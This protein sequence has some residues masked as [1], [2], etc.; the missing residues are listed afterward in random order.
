MDE[1]RPSLV[2]K[3]TELESG[4][5]GGR[6][7]RSLEQLADPDALWE[8]VQ[9]E[10]P[11][12]AA[13]VSGHTGR[14]DFLKL[15]GAVLAMAGLSGCV[16]RPPR[17]T[18]VPYVEAP[19]TVVP[20]KPL[21]FATAMPLNG[22]LTGIL[23]ESHLGRPTKLEG[24]PQHPASL[25]GTNALMHGSLLDLYDPARAQVVTQ[26]GQIN[27]W[28]TF[29]EALH[30]RLEP[31]QGEG[32]AG[33]RILTGTVTSPTLGAQLAR[34]LERFPQARWH[35]Y[36]PVGQDSLRAGAQLAF[37]EP[38][39]TVYHFERAR[40]IV[41]LDAD[42]LFA[43][44]GSVRYALDFIDM[45]RLWNQPEPNRLYVVESTPTMTGAK[46]DNRLALRAGQIEHAARMLA[47]AVGLDVE[48][49]PA[50]TFSQE[51]TAWIEAAARD[52][53]Q[54]RGAGIVIAGPSQPP[55]VHTLAHAIN[56][57]LENTGAAVIHIAPVEAQ[58]VDQLQSLRTLV[59][60]MAA[61]QVNTL[62]IID[63][64]PVLNAP[65]DFDFA[66]Q[67]AQVDFSVQLSLYTDETSELCRWH[68]PMAH[69]LESW[70]DGRAY[71]GTAS[72][73]QPLIAPLFDGKSA[74]ELLAALLGE[75][76]Q[77]SAYEIVRGFWDGYYAELAQPLQ[78][79]AELF[80]R[81]ALYDGVVAGTAFAPVEAQATLDNLPAPT[82]AAE[83]I[84]IS[85]RP[86]PSIWDG[87]FA[88]NVWLQELPKH[89]SLLTWDNAALIA[90]ATAARLNLAAHDL[91]DLHF[92]GRTL[93]AAVWVMPGQPEE[94]VTL[95]LGYGRTAE[96]KISQGLGFN[97][98]ALRTSAAFWF[99]SGLEITRTGST[100][101][102]ASTQQ[103][104]LLA[105][106]DHVRVG[107]L[108]E[109][110]EDPAF[111]QH[112]HSPGAGDGEGRTPPSLF[113]EFEYN[114]YAWGMA[115]DLSACIGC[116]ACIIACEVENNIPVVGKEEVLLGREMHW[117]KVDR[118]YEG[119]TDSPDIHF[120]PRPCMH[121]EKAPCEPVCPVAAT[122]HD[123]EGLNQMVYNRCVG[124]RYCSNNC[125][126][127]VRRFNYYDYID[128]EIPLLK[129]AR[130]PDVTVRVRGV[131]EKCT[132]C[133][134]RINQGRIEAEKQNR[135]I[136]DGEVLTACQQAC[137]TRAIVF[138]DLN[139]PESQVVQW[140]EQ[141]LNYSLL[142]ELGTRPRTTYLAEVRNPNP[143][144]GA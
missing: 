23:A 6:F 4:P 89:I 63:S 25:G 28:E 110:Q 99:G 45:R 36:E 66:A 81:T 120:Q 50:Q 127:K 3:H 29:L 125:P 138:G 126:Y 113:P 91:V 47:R 69:Y 93:E 107:T 84:E 139:D 42:F 67:M 112:A 74:H 18:I 131:M 90:P 31:L 129:L 71:D 75:A 73:L 2:E 15:M 122:V 52:L 100:Y 33:L 134:Q 94:T 10:F 56:Q 7:W 117:I 49:D 9:Q 44:P 128:D 76:G 51:Q 70:S 88:N 144:L 40:R 64:N 38:V 95:Y 96:G 24:N 59:E 17:E 1:Q 27:T 111:A 86:D 104:D 20:G 103:H 37:G 14:R 60:E 78:P 53:E 39:Y 57:T 115:I 65:A 11:R 108:A 136:V 5:D 102:L 123:G 12:Y 141:P 41:S 133:V 43:L 82:P 26:D 80:W 98:Y 30:A 119:E 130:N 143:E 85:F 121:C 48:V 16:A 61:G 8:V 97:S 32:G 140:K 22:Y 35:R 101:P 92:E 106:R 132:Y 114:G 34:L 13:A 109:Y 142:A 55:A 137:P 77:Q 87:R 124:T 68:I 79:D 46:A 72:I 54:H 105:G 62:I 135:T 116:N 19:E 118:Y 83:T 21:F 58:P